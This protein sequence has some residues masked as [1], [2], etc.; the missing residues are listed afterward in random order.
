M[1][2]MAKVDADDTK[3]KICE[4]KY[5]LDKIV[6]NV[7]DPNPFKYNL[8]AFLGAFRSIR[9]FMKWELK[10]TQ[11]DACYKQ[12]KNW[13]DND[14]QIELLTKERNLSTHERII[15]KHN[16][17]AIDVPTIG[18]TG[19]VRAEYTWRFAPDKKIQNIPNINSIISIDIITI[20][21]TCFKELERRISACDQGQL[22]STC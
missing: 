1:L 20:C 5:F 17:V 6:E 13:M 16:D 10:G 7:N 18:G 22:K 21:Q 2:K 11:L 4:A 15:R 3:E 12:L 14:A 9:D 19:K 8:S